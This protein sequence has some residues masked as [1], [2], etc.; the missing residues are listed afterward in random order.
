MNRNARKLLQTPTRDAAFAGHDLRKLTNKSDTTWRSS[1]S[2]TCSVSKC[3][4]F[5]TPITV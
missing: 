4:R 2:A 5:A 3:T 1:S